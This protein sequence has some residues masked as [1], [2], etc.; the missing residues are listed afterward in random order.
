M[1]LTIN[2]K[3]YNAP[4][5]A[6]AIMF[7]YLLFTV[8]TAF[9]QNINIP[10][11]TGPMDLQVNSFTGNMY[12][13]RNDVYI[14]A[15]M[16]D[17]S[18]SFHY[19]SFNFDINNGY[20][21]GW[22]FDYDIRYKN[23]TANG[24]TIVWGDGRED[25]YA[26]TGSNYKSP[27]GFFNV[28]QQ[29]QSGKF[30]LTETD[31]TV[32]FFDNSVHKRITRLQEPNGNFINFNY[33]DT[34]LTSLSNNAGQTISFTYDSKARLST[35][36]DAI[37]SPTRFWTYSYDASNNLTQV[38]DPLGGKS[39]YTYII[40]GPVKSVTDKNNNVVDIIYYNDYTVSEMIG[41]NKRLS[42]SYDTA[43]KTT[44]V[45]DYLESGTNQ[46]TKYKF[47]TAGTNTWLIGMSSNCCGFDMV[48]EYD[49]AGNKIKETDA[50]GNITKYTYDVKG[51]VLTVTD[52]LNQ[53]TSF[54]YSSDFN[55]V[56]SVTDPKGFITTITYDAKGNAIQITEPGNL[57][58]TAAYNSNGDI[59]SSIDPRGQTYTYTYDTYGNPLTVNGPNGFSAV[60]GFDARGNLV[61]FTDANSNTSNIQYDILSRMKQITDPLNNNVQLSYDAM[62][63]TTTIKNKN[64]ENSLLKFD[65]SNRLVQF[66]DAMGKKSSVAYD[67]MDNIIAITDAV[68]NTTTFSY[69]SR[70]RLSGMKDAE[71]NQITYNYDDNGN[72][73]TA[74]LPSGQRYNYSYDALN[75]IKTVTDANS[76]V[77]QFEYDANDNITKIT[78]AT[79][80]TVQLA[81]DSVNRIRKMTDP[82]GNNVELTYD[83]NGNVTSIKD[84]KGSI[85]NI[86]YDNRNRVISFT[87]N[88]GSV[89]TVG[90]DAMSNVT[91]LKD[92]NTNTTTYTYDVLNRVKRM[93]LPD[94]NYT[95]N[96]YD[97]KNNIISRRLT[98]GSIINY[99]YD[100]LN[101]IVSKTLPDGQV[102]SYS[103]DAVGRVTSAT[104]AA[105]TVVFTYDVLNRVTSETFNGRTVKYNYSITG[106]TQTTIY[107]DS[108]A[109]TRNFDT[110]NRLTSIQKNGAT[111]VSYQYNNADQVISKTFANGIT[112]NMQYDFA[113]RLINISTGAFQNLSF[114]YDANG[115]KTSVTRS[116]NNKSEQFTY[117][118]GNR[119]TG[120]KQGPAGGPFTINNSY[121]YDAL[122]NRITAVLNGVTTNYTVNNLNQM[123]SSNNGV[124]NINYTYDGNGNL[125]YDGKFYKT[126]DAEKRLLKDSASPTA[127]ITYTYDAMG[128]RTIK[129]L[130]GTA[131]N[132][133]YAGMEQIE[134]RN[135]SGVLQ[136]RT[137]F[138]HFLE[139]VVNEKNN[140]PFYYHSNDLMSVEFLTNAAGILAEQYDYD[141]YG[142]QT[143]YDGTGTA[144]TGSNTGNRFGFTGQVYDSAT[145]TNKF[146]FREYNPATGLFSQRDLIGY[147]DGM[148]MYQY[149]HN[150]PA[151]GVD[152]LGLKDDPCAGKEMTP[153]QKAFFDRLSHLSNYLSIISE[154][155]KGT[156]LARN[157]YKF[158]DRRSLGAILNVDNK[159]GLDLGKNSK[160]NKANILLQ[161]TNLAVKVN[162]LQN[163]FQTMSTKDVQVEIA[164]IEMAS[165]GLANDLGTFKGIPAF[166]RAVGAVGAVDALAQEVSGH[167]LS[168]HYAHLSDASEKIGDLAARRNEERFQRLEK[169]IDAAMKIQGKDVSKWT[170]EAK[171]QY[172]I[173]VRVLKFRQ[174]NMIQ[175]PKP[176]CPQNGNSRGTQRPSKYRI[177]TV[178]GQLE[179]ITSNDPNAI[180]GPA[181]EPNKR[182]VSV[183]DRLP[184]TVTYEN[185]KSATAPAKYVK[186]F[187][188]V[189]NKMDAAS[190]ELKNIGFNSLTFTVPPAS[191]SNYQRL[192]CRD[193]LG[194]FVDMT[195]GYD[196]VKNQFFWEFQSIDP[197][198][199]L[200]PADPLKGFL[201][202]Q[203]SSNSLYGHGFVNFS[204]KPVANAQT[205]DSIL[206]QAS[207]IF[208]TNDTIPTNIEKN[209][210]DAKA[211]TSNMSS[212]GTNYS[213]SIPLSW[214]G[215]DD[216]NG[217]GIRFFT[218]Y[219]STDGVNYNI[220]RSGI[221]RRDTVFTGTPN[222][223]YYFFVLATD[224][225]GNTET[226]RPGAVVSTQLG[227]TL[228][229]TWLYFNGSTKNKNNILNWATASEQNTDVFIVERSFDA[230]SFTTI[231]TVKAAGNSPSTS[232]YQYID[233]NID[234]LGKTIF[235]YRLKQVDLDGRFSYSS[236]IRL[237]YNEQLT[238]KSMVYPNP[239]S[240]IITIVVGNKKLIG[241]TARVF[242]EAGKL[243]QTVRITA[244]AQS[245]NLSNYLNGIY[246]IILDN[247]ESLKIIK[248]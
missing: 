235:Y 176:D 14:P 239:T 12:F 133:T 33:T 196:V 149:V 246:F 199:L 95:E 221:T 201:L 87:D 144:I 157:V 187:V 71:G 202:R 104:N 15:R 161:V 225:V 197:V 123:L 191:A 8:S 62:G 39:K 163:N 222:T 26:F 75:R 166:S 148:G 30:S 195:A 65:A 227:T 27:V 42:F 155:I 131:M 28:L 113:N 217:C 208:D 171:E 31:G 167:S 41:C 44:V 93:T 186:V 96:T 238:S 102:Y 98:N 142:K 177:N 220:V 35:V 170:K 147:G 121:T 156:S 240:G 232:T 160:F 108:T 6:F 101:R 141:V 206:A 36:T 218:L 135:G 116:N 16:F 245:V 210:I 224:S 51:N 164:E 76:T 23:D 43:Q 89:T 110:R 174:E 231:G 86:T 209:T 162:N 38:T 126:Y 10:N 230:V 219:V 58:Y 112:T 45:T 92:A 120:Y 85:S 212:L 13:T 109:I 80:A 99:T 21:N 88:N 243:L 57:V 61:S 153:E 228:P 194:L 184:Y 67:G 154:S 244:T 25:S 136:N 47:A 103:Y 84:R 68:G 247:K 19:N 185:D 204:I 7:V 237:T 81:Y 172:D 182:W 205:L 49:A 183:K 64:N 63:N 17:L 4:S 146:F 106:R 178:T 119:L 20:G 181:G 50:N 72:I 24:K 3:K 125:S 69:D 134:E 9:S 152:V 54:T 73:I 82:L 40:N 150:N 77:S 90:Y 234:R 18:I 94:G 46:V 158:G 226:L 100:T 248:Q 105:G 107:P 74:N 216:V 143:I 11:K 213:G 242:D 22:S 137:I 211:P 192:D 179:V 114:T 48:F 91:S 175:K 190:F 122:G 145:A 124:Q 189:H 132:Y 34:L 198:T 200:P 151:N 52:A 203:D 70:N 115:N 207:I 111:V 241:T 129:S 214:T 138:N 29:Y 117:D 223:R 56:T 53:T 32:W 139:P 79:G 193:S 118:N 215:A 130:N 83:K 127:V 165:L 60:F 188:P 97:V 236:I 59:T 78:N 169:Y 173:F 168:Y 37:T 2:S 1:N 140:A 229:V 66:T 5:A 159:A 55:K 233:E 180:I 128:R